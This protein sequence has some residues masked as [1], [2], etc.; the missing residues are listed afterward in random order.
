[1]S[2]RMTIRAWKDEEYRLS[3]SEAERSQLPENPAGAVELTDSD[4]GAAVGGMLIPLPSTHVPRIMS[5][6][7]MIWSGRRAM[8]VMRT[9]SLSWYQSTP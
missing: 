2:H 4:L 7:F 1:M 6:T 5:R 3:L 8:S 9:R